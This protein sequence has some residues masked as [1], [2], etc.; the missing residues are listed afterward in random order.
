M[1][2]PEF[3]PFFRY[4]DL[5]PCQPKLYRKIELFAPLYAIKQ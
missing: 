5:H 1:L 2:L 4:S 3:R